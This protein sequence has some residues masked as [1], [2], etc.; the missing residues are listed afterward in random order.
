MRPSTPHR[1][2]RRGQRLLA[3][4]T[5]AL[6]WAGCAAPPLVLRIGIDPA[7]PASSR[8]AG[9]LADYE[10]AVRAVSALLTQELGVPLPRE[11]TVFVYPS[12]W[13]YA[14]GLADVG[15]FPLAQATE[16]A[17]YSVGLGQARRLLINDA[18]LRDAPRSVWLGVLAHELTHVAQYELSGGR[19]GGSEQWLREGMAD[20]VACWVVERLGAGTFQE[21]WD[22]AWQAVAYALPALGDDPVDLVD[23]GRPR[24]WETRHLRAGDR[25]TYRLAFLLTDE[26]IQRHGFERV[27]AYF[28][29]F[30]D[31]EDR[32]GNFRWAFGASVE[33]FEAQALG[34]LRA[35]LGELAPAAPRYPMPERV[36]R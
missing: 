28:R 20:W 31:S 22:R 11:F 32:F 30:G 3:I 25:L 14:E 19:R 24:G 12:Q 10:T 36:S 27:V 34:R 7:A 16:I 1:A 6:L 17:R 26:L 18:A 8:P 4:A 35:K 23:L 13:A 21:E 9:T 2:E 5:L 33:E 15:E 29:A